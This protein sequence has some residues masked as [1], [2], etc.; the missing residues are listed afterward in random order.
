MRILQ[1]ALA[2]P[3]CMGRTVF[4]SLGVAPCRW[5]GGSVHGGPDLLQHQH[6]RSPS[7]RSVDVVSARRPVR[8]GGDRRRI[9]GSVLRTRKGGGAADGAGSFQDLNFAADVGAYRYV[10][11]RLRLTD[12]ASGATS[13][14][15]TI[16]IQT[17]T[18]NRMEEYVAVP[19]SGGADLEF[20]VAYN[21]AAGDIE[22]EVSENFARYLRWVVTGWSLSGGTNDKIAFSIDLVLKN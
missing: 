12:I 9:D 18:Q 7:R 1:E 2:P 15:V 3:P 14:S 10:A 6:R 4:A 20:T 13:G 17:A 22:L 16:Q 11:A 19:G 5:G 21:A 8:S